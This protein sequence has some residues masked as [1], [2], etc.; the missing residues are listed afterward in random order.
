MKTITVNLG[1][2]S[3]EEIKDLLHSLPSEDAVLQLNIG[4]KNFGVRTNGH[5]E[6]LPSLVEKQADTSLIVYEHERYP[7]K[8]QPLNGLTQWVRN[9]VRE[10]N[11]RINL[12]SITRAARIKYRKIKESNMR[13]CLKTVLKFE[14]VEK[15][16][17]LSNEN[18]LKKVRA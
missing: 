15:D 7:T 18:V 4:S 9:Y 8:D 14:E 3:I 12:S 13:N 11:V 17:F 16:I 1:G 5:V 10:P 6:V 2:Y